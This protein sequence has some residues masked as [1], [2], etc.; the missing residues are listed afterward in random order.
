LITF[1][2]KHSG[3]QCHTA[4]CSW[5]ILFEFDHRL[6]ELLLSASCSA[7]EQAWKEYLKQPTNIGTHQEINDIHRN[8]T[9][10]VLHE[11]KP[12]LNVYGQLQPFAR[13]L[14]MK[15]AATLAP[16]SQMCQVIIRNT[17]SPD[18]ALSSSS[19]SSLHIGRSQSHMTPNHIQVLCPR[20]TE[21][22]Q[23]ETAMN[24]IYTKDVLPFP[25]MKGSDNPFRA[26]AHSVMRKLSMV[27]I[28][29]TFSR[30]SASLASLH[31]SRP[32]QPVIHAH[33]VFEKHS[34]HRLAPRSRSGETAKT[35]AMTGAALA[36]PPKPAI[37]FHSAPEAF[38]P[39]DFS[40]RG[41]RIQ[42]L[43]RNSAGGLRAVASKKVLNDNPHVPEHKRLKRSMSMQ[44]TDSLYNDVKH[45]VSERPRL[46]TT[47]SEV[48]RRKSLDG[49]KV[50][51][52]LAYSPGPPGKENGQ[53]DGHAGVGITIPSKPLSR[54]L[55]D[56]MR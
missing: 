36:P 37:D 34:R 6:F 38:L 25:G 17:V 13:R 26:S 55:R 46:L 31:S 51:D 23:L 5:K 56:L 47:M 44:A 24:D 16:R 42:T 8:L 15:R 50:L 3:L 45:V 29:S 1:S 30:R 9:S 10:E 49:A 22:V 33:D 11:I 7:E 20:R 53:P 21:R 19:S 41:P 27:S 32:K 2:Y 4:P 43:P 54:R 39:P 48:T 35:L 40:L 18:H 12:V 14:S 52:S 28:S